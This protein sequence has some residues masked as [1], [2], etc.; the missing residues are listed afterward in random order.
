V[1]RTRGER[2]GARLELRREALSKTAAHLSIISAERLLTVAEHA[3]DLE[4]DNAAVTQ[5]LAISGASDRDWDADNVMEFLE[6]LEADD[7]SRYRVV[8]E[9]VLASLGAIQM[10][11]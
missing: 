5:L 8:L 2:R 10:S 1:S 9:A 7:G 4:V 6:L 11:D 3:L